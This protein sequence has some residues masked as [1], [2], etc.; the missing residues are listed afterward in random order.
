MGSIPIGGFASAEARV[1]RRCLKK[2]GDKNRLPATDTFQVTWGYGVAWSSIGALGASD[3]G[4]KQSL[5]SK[6]ALE[7]KN[8][9]LNG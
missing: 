3:P 5:F 6:K 8:L 2:E 7:P 1:E 4:S 9:Y